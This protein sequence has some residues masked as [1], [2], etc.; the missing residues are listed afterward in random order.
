MLLRHAVESLGSDPLVPREVALEISG[1]VQKDAVCVELI[2][3]AA[4]SAQR[5]E[6][7]D[8]L[9]FC[10]DAPAL[11]LIGCG[12]RVQQPGQLDVGRLV[13]LGARTARSGC[14]RKL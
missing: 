11:Q 4:E 3:L 5:L 9:R 8:K 14:A 2:G 10:L 1:I 12:A 13:Q 7:I 6:A